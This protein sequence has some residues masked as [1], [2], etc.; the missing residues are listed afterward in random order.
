[1]RRTEVPPLDEDKI[2]DA[3]IGLDMDALGGKDLGSLSIRQAPKKKKGRAKGVWILVGFLLGVGLAGFVFWE[4]SPTT[5]NVP[6]RSHSA[7]LFSY[8]VEGIRIQ[9]LALQKEGEQAEA[10]SVLLREQTLRVVYGKES[11]RFVS[12]ERDPSIWAR[13]LAVFLSPPGLYLEGNPIDPGQD[14]ISFLAPEKSLVYE[15]SLRAGPHGPALARF[16]LELQMSAETWAARARELKEPQAQRACLEQALRA[17]PGNVDLLMA[18]GNLLWE[19]NEPLGAAERFEEVLKH[20]PKHKEAARALASIYSKSKPKRALEMYKLLSDIDP[21]NRL[22]NLKH[23]A[24]LQERLG[25]S[26]AETYKKILAIQKN[27]P[28]ARRGLD[29]LYAKKVEMAQQAE[30]KGNL[31]QAIEQMKQALEL[32]PSKEGKAY[33]ATLHNNLAYSLAKQAKFK[34]AIPHYEASLRL[35]ESAITYLNLADA[36]AK[37]QQHSKALQ[38]VEKAWALKPKEPEVVK[39][40]LLLWAELLTQK[41]DYGGATAKLQ[42]L[43]AKFPK[44]PEVA[45]MLAAA[46]WNQKDLNKALE[47][48]QRVPGLMASHPPKARAEIHAM[49]GDLYRAL[50]DQEKNVKGRIARYDEALKEYKAALALNKGDKQTQ[51]KKEELESERM[52]LVKRSLKSS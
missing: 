43:H 52:A 8:P 4:I 28:D 26:P 31:S 51:K 30:K 36:Y 41:K 25:V 50:G 24:A 7:S 11:V 13:V 12:V 32:N 29:T 44:D 14:L 34:E 35:E 16:T 23:M 3:P 5:E 48:L 2:L 47:V 46:Y 22:D 1:M 19:Q 21:D 27:D 49:L 18:L 38:S 15:L 33:L 42:E 20:S 40:L 39:N 6:R 17:E 10:S 45:K 9:R 37:A